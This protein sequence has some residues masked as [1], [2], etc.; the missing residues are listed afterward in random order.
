[1]A[2]TPNTTPARLIRERLPVRAGAHP[3]DPVP[4]SE[5]CLEQLKLKKTLALE[6]RAAD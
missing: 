1:M 6:M 2:Y 5:R 4:A 3:M